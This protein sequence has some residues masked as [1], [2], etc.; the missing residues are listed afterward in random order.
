MPFLVPIA[1]KERKMSVQHKQSTLKRRPRQQWSRV[2]V[3]LTAEDEAR[4]RQLAACEARSPA[5]LLRLLALRH[6][7]QQRQQ[8]AA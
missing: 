8:T 3:R 6:I 5:N 1:A 4:L 7:E 2:Q